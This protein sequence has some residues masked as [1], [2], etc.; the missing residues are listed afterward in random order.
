MKSMLRNTIFLILFSLCSSYCF[1]TNFYVSNSGLNSNIGSESEPFQT[2]QYGFD[3]LTPGDSLLVRAGTYFEKLYCNVSGSNGNQIVIINYPGESPIVDG[4][5]ISGLEMLAINT[6]SYITIEGLIFQNNY[7]QDARGIL[8]TSEANDIYIKKCTIRNIGWTTDPLA[9]PYSVTPTGQAHGIIFNGRTTS[10]IHDI[11]IT[12]CKVHDIITGNSEAMTLVGNVYNFEIAR[13]TV[14]DTKNIGIVVAGHYAW[15]IDSGVDAALNQSRDGVIKECKVYSN[16]R[17]SN[18]DAPAGIYADGASNVLIH[19]NESFD[20]GNGMS[21]GCENTG[22]TASNITV[23]NNLIYNNDNQG[24]YWGSNAA[25]LTNSTLK[26]NTF[27]HNGSNGSFYAEVSLQNSS[28]CSI[29]QNIIIPKTISHY[30]VSIFG[31][32]V[33]NL[34]VDN[35]LAYRYINDFQNLFITDNQFTPTNTINLDPEFIDTTITSPNLEIQNDSPAIDKG[36]T[37]YGYEE[38][39]DFAGNNRIVNGKLDHGAVENIN[40]LC[41]LI[42]TIDNTYILSGKYTAQNKVEFDLLGS[43]ISGPIDVFCPAVNILS[44]ISITNLINTYPIGCSN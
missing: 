12:D 41:P 25:S 44:S 30:A 13:D 18:F 6:K 27:L 15:A 36:L 16:R 23:V 9:D 19:K 35:N 11:G 40:G 26:N 4:T 1:C 7:T 34:T 2:I 37:S 31:Y 17:F 32:V 21:V 29:I 20:N 39:I 38:Q 5:G 33:T 14:Y 43:S 24:I 28:D 42:L 10:G 22:K 3:Q 8:V